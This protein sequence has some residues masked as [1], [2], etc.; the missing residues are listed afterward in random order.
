MKVIL[1]E[2]VINL[3][4]LGDIVNVKDGYARNFLMPGA[5]AKR[6]TDANLKAFEAKRSE[7][8]EIQA[9]GLEKAQSLFAKLNDKV[10]NIQAKSGVDGKLF[11]SVTSMDI[12][13]IIKSVAEVVLEKSAILLP[14]G[15]LKIIGEFE[16]EVLLHHGVRAKVKINIQPVS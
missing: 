13:D 8:E 16:V 9:K 10:F 6:A 7:Y 14:N 5:K 2:K 1:L 12:V 11:G 15:P 3:G 4:N